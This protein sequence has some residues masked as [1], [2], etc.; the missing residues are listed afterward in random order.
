MI[1]QKRN[2]RIYLTESETKPLLKQ[3]VSASGNPQDI[4]D[5]LFQNL[6]DDALTM[7]TK[8]IMGVKPQL[9]YKIGDIVLVNLNDLS[10][11][12]DHEKTIR[13]GLAKDG[14]VRCM[15]TKIQKWKHM[16]PYTIKFR[17]IGSDGK[18]KTKIEEIYTSYIQPEEE[19][20]ENL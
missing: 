11:T 16:Y 20:P 13:A 6:S 5:A 2:I 19:F 15:I 7:V 10:Y 14:F 4:A 17:Y 3:M 9:E 1:M 18:V 12:C 8:A